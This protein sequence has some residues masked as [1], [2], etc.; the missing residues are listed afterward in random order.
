MFQLGFDLTRTLRFNSDT[1]WVKY[2][3]PALSL[4]RGYVSTFNEVLLH[5]APAVEVSFGVGVDPRVLDPVT[6]EY[7]LIGRDVF[8]FERNANGFVAE[9]NYLSLAPQIAGAE[10][11]LQDLR[12]YQVRAIVRF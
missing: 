1:R 11:T 6:N 8:L 9:T 3:V 10:Q 2:D 5:P 12:R 4:G 7:G